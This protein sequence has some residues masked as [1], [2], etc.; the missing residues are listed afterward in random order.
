LV[1]KIIR[2]A[3]FDW[4]DQ[5]AELGGRTLADACLVPT[6]IYTNVI[7]SVQSHYRIKHVIHGLAHI[8]GGGFQEN[9]NRILPGSVDALIDP[10][11]WQLPAIFT[12]L[13]K[14][15]N[16]DSGEMRRV[17]NMGI[18]MAMVVSDFYAPSICAQIVGM[19]VPCQ[20]VGK[21]VPGSGIVRFTDEVS[22]DA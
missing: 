16:V 12:W 4:N 11:A 3:G 20:P 17:F 5:P 2:D 15:G 19:G 22:R 7:R 10:D 9:L 8:T 14:T 6:R 18:G 1:R 21:I 13:Q